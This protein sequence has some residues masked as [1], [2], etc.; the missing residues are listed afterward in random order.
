[1]LNGSSAFVAPEL[2]DRGLWDHPLLDPDTAVGGFVI[3]PIGPWATGAHSI[4][5]LSYEAWI[6]RR[7]QIRMKDYVNGYSI[8][9]F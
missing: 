9:G 7:T 4:S 8:A 1:V 2:I 3:L 5:W 6:H